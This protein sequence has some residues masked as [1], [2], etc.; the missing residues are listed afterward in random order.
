M[1]AVENAAFEAGKENGIRQER[2]E[3]KKVDQETKEKHEEELFKKWVAGR[4]KG[5][6]KGIKQGLVE[7]VQKGMAERITI[8]RG[9]GKE[10][11]KTRGGEAKGAGKG[12]EIDEDE[13]WRAH[14]TGFETGAR[15]IG[16]ETHH[17]GYCMG[18]DAAI[19]ETQERERAIGHAAGYALGQDHSENEHEGWKKGKA[20][21]KQIGRREGRQE[22]QEKARLRGWC[23]A[24]P[25]LQ[26]SFFSLRIFG[27]S[28]A[29]SGVRG[30]VEMIVSRRA[31]SGLDISPCG[32]IW[33][34]F[35]PHSTNP[36]KR[37]LGP[38]FGP[39]PGPRARPKNKSKTWS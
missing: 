36:S 30:V 39:G 11:G 31:P 15:V 20:E 18:R 33:T 1:W 5:Y 8:A 2:E 27:P 16:E 21:G 28:M 6:G 10:K 13:W 38:V 17:Y 4:D 32:A 25:T 7:G 14:Q 37:I 26:D 35:K 34:H 22:Q 3:Q 19:A 12:K 9:E 23:E 24:W 29:L